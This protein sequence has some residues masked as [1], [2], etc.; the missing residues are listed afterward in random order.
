MT[1]DIEKSFKSRL[2]TIAKEQG[3]DPADLWQT[4]MLE[5]FLARLA[6]ASTGSHF[7]LKGAILRLAS[8][9]YSIENDV[10]WT[11]DFQ[12]NRHNISQWS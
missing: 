12:L 1:S 10:D 3:R 5:R 8:I 4:L 6:Q 2:R 7:I 11:E 9:A